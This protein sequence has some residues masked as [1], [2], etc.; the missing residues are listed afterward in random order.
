[1]SLPSSIR[2]ITFVCTDVGEIKFSWAI[3]WSKR[4]S[5]PKDVKV[6]LSGV[7]AGDSTGVG[8]CS[9]FNLRFMVTRMRVIRAQERPL[10]LHHISKELSKVLYGKVRCNVNHAC[11]VLLPLRMR[12]VCN[13]ITPRASPNYLYFM[14]RSS[15]KIAWLGITYGDVDNLRLYPYVN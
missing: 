10:C 11:N 9:S 15:C 7:D 1:M 13:F 12:A 5:R 2:G 6:A 3:A 14:V 4:E 8:I